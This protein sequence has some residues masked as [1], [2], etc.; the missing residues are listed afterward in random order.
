MH[1]LLQD[2][3]ATTTSAQCWHCHATC[4]R[5]NVINNSNGTVSKQAAADLLLTQNSVFYRVESMHEQQRH[6]SSIALLF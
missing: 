3:G 5:S 2:S 4:K 6:Q 1:A